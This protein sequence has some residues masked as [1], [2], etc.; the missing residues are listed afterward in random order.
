[1]LSSP[2]DRT[3]VEPGIGPSSTAKL[4][5]SAICIGK[6]TINGARTASFSVS[7]PRQPL[8]ELG[9]AATWRSSDTPYGVISASAPPFWCSSRIPTFSESKR[10][11]ARVFTGRPP[12]I[13]PSGTTGLW[14][15]STS[16]TL[17]GRPFP[18]FALGETADGNKGLGWRNLDG[19]GGRF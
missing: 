3:F 17:G 14:M 7:M 10:P 19:R 4:F 13:P 8:S 6:K 15:A 11:T 12:W 2:N 1:M 9:V 18:C 5:A 16:L